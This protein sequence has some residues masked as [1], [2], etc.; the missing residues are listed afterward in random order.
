MAK[1]PKHH[2]I[3]EF[4]LQQWTDLASRTLV[5]FCRR[6]QGVVARPTFPGGTGYIRGLYKLPDAPQGEEHIIE[7][8]LM[9]SIDNWASK[10]LQSMLIDG[11]FPG[12][13]DGHLALGWCQFLY[14]LIVR[15]PEHLERMKEKMA[16]L[17]PAEVIENIRDD[18]PRLRGPGDP[19]TF[20]EY[21][22]AFRLKPVEVPAIR[23]L[24]ELVRSK[25]VVGVLASFRWQTMTMNAAKY[26]LLT[27]DRP[28]I[29]TNG[30]A[31]TNAYIV[32]PISPRKLFIAT[33]TEETFQYFVEM[34]SKELAESVNN[35]VSQQAHRFVFG[36]DD[37][38]LRF[39]SNRLGKRVW[40]SP[41]G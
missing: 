1:E 35:Q 22:A 10:A 39:V 17:D 20:D 19:L 4:Y 32:L 11:P 9:Q 40:S 24:P 16:T 18:Y 15:T 41:L 13:L 37:S 2:Y 21:K 6:Y 5:E 8:K 7:T 3:P 25:R 23:V 33:K 28:I 31:Q 34:N 27:S 14:S 29:M 38:Q 30:L 12:K 36:S 26:P